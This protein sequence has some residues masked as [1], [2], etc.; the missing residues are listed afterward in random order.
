LSRYVALDL[1]KNYIYGGEW[2]AGETGKRHF[3]VPNTPEGWSQLLTRLDATCRVAVEVTGNAFELCDLLSPHVAEVLPANPLALKRLGSG[4]HTDKVDVDRLAQMIALGTVPTVWVPPEPVRGTRRLLRHRERL[5]S[6]RRGFVNQA[7]AVLRRHGVPLP[8]EADIRRAVERS[9]V[10][11][12]P[13]EERVILLSAL[14][15]VSQVEHDL[16]DIEAEVARQ[17]A[18]VPEVRCLLTI[19]GIGI[20]TA[21]TIWAGIGDPHRFHRPRELSRYAGLDATVMQSGE[22]NSRGHISKQGNRLLRAALIQAANVV[23][24]HDTGY[25]GQFYRRKVAKLGHNRA[26]VATA[27]KLLIVAWQLMLT[28]RAYRGVRPQVMKHKLIELRRL[29]ERPAPW[30]ALLDEYF[31]ATPCRP[32]CRR[33]A[34]APA[35]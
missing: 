17:V 4:R 20:V 25:L 7:K 14:R 28:G 27:R 31:P 23:A 11:S 6:Q 9:I 18:H 13:A 1:H 22:Q 2:T 8:K 19:S 24:L 10:E 16:A 21:A 15:Q 30:Q 3:R 34:R 32:T 12:L 29:V 33:R 35:A 5:S 26:V